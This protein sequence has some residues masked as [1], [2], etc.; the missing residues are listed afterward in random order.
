MNEYDRLGISIPFGRTS[1]NIKTKCP[2]CS[3][4]RKNKSDRALSVNLNEGLYNCHYCGWSG[5]VKKKEFIP[6]QKEYRKPK[7]ENKTEL[8]DKVVKWFQERGISQKTLTK[9]KIAEGLH[10]IPAKG[11]QANCIQFPFFLDGEVVN[12]KY[13]TGDKNWAVEAGCELILWNID[14]LVGEKYAIITEGE[15]DAMSFIECGYKSVVSVPNGANGTDYLDN[16]IESYFDDKDTIYIAVDNDKKGLILRA[17]LIRRFGAERCRIVEY[18]NGCKDG[19]EHLIKYGWESLKIA[20]EQSADIKIDGIFSVK[21]NEESLDNLYLNGLQKGYTI[22][23]ENFDR[24]ISFETGRM[25]LVTGIPGHGKSEFVD[26]IVILL[27]ILHKMKF[28]YFSPENYPAIYLLSK[29][30]S[31]VTGRKF[32][33]DS[34]DRKEYEES[35]RYLDNNIFMIYPEED[36]TLDS[37]LNKAKYLIKKKGI[38]GLIIDPWNKLEHQIPNGMSET[39]YISKQLDKITSFAQRNDVLIF[40][41]AH[42]TKMKKVDGVFEIPTL[43]DISGSAHFYNKTDYGITVYRDNTKGVVTVCVQKVKFKHLGEVGET[44]FKYNMN[45]GRYVPY[46][47]QA[48]ITW[49]NK[50]YLQILKE[51]ENNDTQTGFDFNSLSRD[52]LESDFLSE[53]LS[54]DNVPF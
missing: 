39:Q 45:N 4:T 16:Y 20:V 52:K 44:D 22:G 14:S 5:T 26:E 15:I 47:G 25:C 13:R 38:K 49:N 10:Y 50:N 21:D 9:T 19:N 8:S 32:G 1:G 34:L 2:K 37:I 24:L 12:V 54:Y 36:L 23:H 3:G 29:L 41:I 40:V 33:S 18:G 48:E 51:S 30:I 11:K 53:P 31:K 27:N 28:A 46:F 42:P 7:F 35:K 17:D 43:Y 6:M